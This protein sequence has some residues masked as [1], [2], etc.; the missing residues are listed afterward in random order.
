MYCKLNTQNV[1][2]DLIPRDFYQTT[3]A[4]LSHS[5]KLAFIEKYRLKRLHCISKQVFTMFLTANLLALRVP[6]RRCLSAVRT[7]S[8]QPSWG[9]FIDNTCARYILIMV[10]FIYTYDV[11]SKA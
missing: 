9:T 6:N 11:E 7:S 5:I 8:D 2:C 1:F 4:K 3:N 10:S